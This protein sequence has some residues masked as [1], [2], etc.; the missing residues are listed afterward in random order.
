MERVAIKSTTVV[1]VKTVKN[2]AGP[3]V[4]LKVINRGT[5]REI[6]V[7]KIIHNG[8]IAQQEIVAP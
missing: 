6:H 2:Q 1:Q 3:S 8:G 7:A 5:P 4:S